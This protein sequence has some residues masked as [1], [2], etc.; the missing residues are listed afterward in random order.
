MDFPSDWGLVDLEDP[1][2]LEFLE[3]LQ[4]PAHTMSTVQV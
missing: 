4:V 1:V 3:Y 2:V